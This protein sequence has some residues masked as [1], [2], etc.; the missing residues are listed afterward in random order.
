MRKL[1]VHIFIS[2]SIL[3]GIS[4][5]F[6][7]CKDKNIHKES[8][9]VFSPR[10]NK[11]A[12]LAGNKK[13]EWKIE[14]YIINGKN[15][16][17]KLKDCEKDNLDVYFTDHRFESIEGKKKCKAGDPYLTD[18]GYWY[19]NEDTT[20]IEVTIGYDFYILKL[21]EL[22]SNKFHYISITNSDTIEAVLTP[23]VI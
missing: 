16:L 7:S 14:K 12:T 1:L 5:V 18:T 8:Q 6:H 17:K 2:A 3:F 19:F 21:I 10:S 22:S 15:K 20:E 23:H 11:T 4:I 9:S 13:K